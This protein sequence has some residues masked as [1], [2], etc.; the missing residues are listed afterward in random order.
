MIN[1]EIAIVNPKS[2]W[3]LSI[4]LFLKSTIITENM[5]SITDITIVIIFTL[6]F[7]KKSNIT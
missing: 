7:S 5:N 2:V 4:C 3:H 6:D 1:P